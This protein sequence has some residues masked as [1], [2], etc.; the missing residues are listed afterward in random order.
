MQPLIQQDTGRTFIR[1]SNPIPA[2]FEKTAVA[3]IP[4]ALLVGEN[5]QGSWCLARCLRERGCRCEFASSSQQA[6][7]LVQNLDL[8]LVL[9]PV[10]LRNVSL[11]FLMELLDGSEVTL[12][13]FQAVERGCWWL[14]A[15]REG[16]RCLGSSALSPSEFVSVLDGVIDE[17]RLRST[18]G[19]RGPRSLFGKV[20]IG[21]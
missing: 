10:R 15:I 2:G 9:S 21:R 11:L 4:N 20:A 5:A 18:G 6:F 17:V 14:P 3:K 16:E 1:Q 13:Y 7:S 8:D 19:G 12:F